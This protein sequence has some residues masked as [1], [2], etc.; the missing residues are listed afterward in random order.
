MPKI[1]MAMIDSLL[2]I[3][4]FFNIIS[5]IIF[6]YYCVLYIIDIKKDYSDDS[7]KA[8]IVELLKRNAEILKENETIKKQIAAFNRDNNNIR[9]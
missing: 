8:L 3:M 5:C 4:G 7:D 1:H 9:N 6:I 2:Y